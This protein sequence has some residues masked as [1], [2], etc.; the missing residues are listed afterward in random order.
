MIELKILPTIFLKG[1]VLSLLYFYI[2]KANDTTLYNISVFVIFYT[3]FSIT[4]LSTN[5]NQDVVTT[6]FLTKTIFTLI[7]E[8]MKKEK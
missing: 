3:I 2:T 4:A 6:A 1:F 8:R 7:D 5:I